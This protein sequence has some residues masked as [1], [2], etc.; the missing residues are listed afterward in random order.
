MFRFSFRFCFGSFRFYSV[1]DVSF[2]FSFCA[3]SSCHF[4]SLWFWQRQEGE[5]EPQKVSGSAWTFFFRF[6]YVF[7]TFS[8]S[9]F[10]LP[11]FPPP[12]PISPAPSQSSFIFVLGCRFNLVSM[13]R[14]LIVFVVSD[15]PFFYRFHVTFFISFRCFRQTVFYRFAKRNYQNTLFLKTIKKHPQRFQEKLCIY[16]YIYIYKKWKTK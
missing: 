6:Q 3:F 1:F 10:M 13:W 12:L 4:F 15:K 9:A 11:K 7:D 5:M 2:F 8:I 16:I 14:F